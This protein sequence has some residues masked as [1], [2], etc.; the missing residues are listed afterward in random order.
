MLVVAPALAWAADSTS[1]T[2]ASTSFKV[3]SPVPSSG[4]AYAI[5]PGDTFQIQFDVNNDST[6]AVDLMSLA[7]RYQ[8]QV[9]T[10]DNEFSTIAAAFFESITVLDENGGVLGTAGAITGPNTTISINTTLGAGNNT[11]PSKDTRR[12]YLCIKSALTA[13]QATFYIEVKSNVGGGVTCDDG[14]GNFATVTHDL[15][16]DVCQIVRPK[17][18][19]AGAGRYPKVIAAG[20]G[21]YDLFEWIVRN[22]TAGTFTYRG[23]TYTCT[24]VRG[25]VPGAQNYY[26]TNPLGFT[27]DIERF[28]TV[29]D[30]TEKN[31]N[32]RGTVNSPQLRN[33][34]TAAPFYT[35]YQKLR[36]DAD[37]DDEPVDIG[38]NTSRTMQLAFVLNEYISDLP[39]P[40]GVVPGDCWYASLDSFAMTIKP[41]A[42]SFVK[43]QDVTTLTQRISTVIY[44]LMGPVG[45]RH[46]V[47]HPH[48]DATGSAYNDANDLEFTTYR[49]LFGLALIG[50]A[51]NTQG[52][53][54]ITLN[55]HHSPGLDFNSETSPLRRIDQTVLSGLQIRST[56]DPTYGM[57]DPMYPLDASQTLVTRTS[58]NTTRVQL[59][60]SGFM[61]L[62]TDSALHLNTTDQARVWIGVE[63]SQFAAFGD[64][65]TFELPPGGLEFLSGLRVY[66]T[67][68]QSRLSAADT[69]L[70]SYLKLD[71]QA[72][73]YPL[74]ETAA[75]THG[76]PVIFRDLTS[77]GQSVPPSSQAI[78]CF[79]FNVWDSGAAA[80]LFEASFFLLDNVAG[81]GGAIHEQDFADLRN[82]SQSGW[83]IYRDND[84]HP[85]NTNGVFDPNIDS[86]VPFT[87]FAAAQTR[88][89]PVG[90]PYSATL[91]NSYGAVNQ[92]LIVR[93]EMD[94]SNAATAVPDNDRDSNGGDDF[95][96]VF[97]TSPTITPGDRFRVIFGDLDNTVVN[98]YNYGI[99][100]QAQEALYWAAPDRVFSGG[101]FYRFDTACQDFG[102]DPLTWGLLTQ[103]DIQNNPN[104]TGAGSS[105]ILR[106][107]VIA[108]T[109]GIAVNATNLVVGPKTVF[110]GNELPLFGLNAV[111][112]TGGSYIV[113][114]YVDLIDSG[115]VLGDFDT[116]QDLSRF[117]SNLNTRGQ[118]LTVFED[119][120]TT[121]GVFDAGDSPVN[122]IWSYDS[123]FAGGTTRVKFTFSPAFDM[124]DTDF[125]RFAGNDIFI[126]AK[127]GD[128]L[129][130]RDDFAFRLPGNTT[131]NGMTFA[132]PGFISV[133]PPVTTGLL[134]AG[135]PSVYRDLPDSGVLSI[136][137]TRLAVM[138]IM[139]AD[140][141]HVATNGGI[142]LDQVRIQLEDPSAPGG[143]RTTDLLPLDV[144][145][146]GSGIW[147]WRDM[148]GSRTFSET[149]DTAL[150]IS[151]F[152]WQSANDLI[153]DVDNALAPVPDT[154]PFNLRSET[155]AVYFLVFR[156]AAAGL[157]HKLKVSVQAVNEPL[158]PWVKFTAPIDRTMNYTSNILTISPAG[159]TGSFSPLEFSPNADGVTDTIRI[160][161]T[162]IPGNLDSSWSLSAT[163]IASNVTSNLGVGKFDSVVFIGKT[164][165]AGHPVTY[166]WPSNF[167]SGGAY[168]LSFAYDRAGTTK[169]YEFG[170]TLLVD[171]SCTAPVL[172][173]ALPTVLTS[174]STVAVSI[175]SDTNRS[176]LDA[177]ALTAGESAA[178]YYIYRLDGTVATLLVSGTLANYVA[179]NVSVPIQGGTNNLV[180]NLRDT[181]GNW[182]DTK[183]LGAVTLSIGS[184]QT[185]VSDILTDP[186]KR[187]IGLGDSAAVF[188]INVTQDLA[189]EAI[190][191]ITLRIFD[192]VA[193]SFAYGNNVASVPTTGSYTETCG[194][195]VYKDNTAGGVK[196]S[197]D[198]ADII[199]PLN[200]AQ[201]NSIFSSGDTVRLIPQTPLPV[202][203]NDTSATYQGYDY[204]VVIV[205]GGGGY[206]RDSFTLQMPATTAFEF[207]TTS[208]TRSNLGS[209][210]TTA[211]I[212]TRIPRTF[213]DLS[214][215]V[216]SM[217]VGSNAAAILGIHVADTTR[218]VDGGAAL[219]TITLNF[220][221][222]AG[223]TFNPA[224]LAFSVY[225]D[226]GSTD[227]GSFNRSNDSEVTTTATILS[228]TSVLLTLSGANAGI[229]GSDAGNDSGADFW[230]AIR[231]TV[232]AV[233][234]ANKFTPWIP[235]GGVVTDG[236]SPGGLGIRAAS[237]ITI[238]VGGI[239][240]LISPNPFRPFADRYSNAYNYYETAGYALSFAD[241]RGFTVW[242]NRVTTG[243]TFMTITGYAKDTVVVF[244]RT[245]TTNWKMDEYRVTLRDTVTNLSSLD[246]T[247][248]YADT[249]ALTPTLG[250]APPASTTGTSLSVTIRVSELAENASQRARSRSER[251][252]FMLVFR[253]TAADG[254]DSTDTAYGALTASTVDVTKTISLGSGQNTVRVTLV[255]KVGNYD[256]TLTFSISSGA[257]IIGNIGF[258]GNSPLFRY[259]SA[260]PAFT[261]TFPTTVSGGTLEFFNI[262]GERMK[263]I[264]LP[265]GISSV[266]WN[267][268]NDAGQ[269]L[270]N[271]VYIIKFKVPL[272]NGT[273]IEESRTIFLLK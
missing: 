154:D 102:Q 33:W 202:P 257:A 36:N 79:G 171:L 211:P 122:G 267:A 231:P 54:K 149:A 14:G 134:T 169:T 243:E 266:D 192:S 160:Q 242:L 188:G 117:V 182:S 204:Y 93:L 118:G 186:T 180:A 216:D 130:F 145:D 210:V 258:E 174:G 53:R 163:H 236:D 43:N 214:A 220:D 87:G 173:S 21:P 11:I 170:D 110:R 217:P 91:L 139:A 127:I 98:T 51:N 6:V 109:G 32:R 101:A 251:D 89:V 114:L 164:A 235:A 99:S 68:P 272:S 237:A 150:Q 250:S 116:G 10:P 269:V 77:S 262:A 168:R 50:G 69:Y 56:S 162:I 155:Q 76:M 86:F 41:A 225:N 197:F 271:G 224:I 115:L 80:R 203:E 207:A 241:S 103:L 193:G 255:D 12:F 107:E 223:D 23:T 29:I 9:S 172:T 252:S 4:M 100:F 7:F 20:A 65:I 73:V 27:G 42:S 123:F 175:S 141:T 74:S 222:A 113:S 17:T 156:A 90:N 40:G 254:T 259:T 200:P 60:I 84:S 131:A 185:I 208:G 15:K 66:E 1:V 3:P 64:S 45:P 158:D 5:F 35:I 126:V 22:R 67:S 108:V 199:V 96:L 239:S 81:G 265:P 218:A 263:I 132:P 152:T 72:I 213:R 37:D 58:A 112:T 195:L 268:A 133:P 88:Y 8:D 44:E 136:D 240:T 179:T 105:D 125:G 39:Q 229:P 120:G 246:A 52:L 228:A 26:Q 198:A 256:S 206:Y 137:G 57:T 55:L 146:S 176:T 187:W 205:G 232:T 95:F 2:V 245:D 106:S 209:P 83:A 25:F 273:T 247:L 153:I 144:N 104:Y 264:N 196:G 138:G 234:V 140:S 151:S 183:T 147:I 34:S 24:N 167:T 31:F 219:R 135:M 248:L 78:A 46:R 121:E 249:Q 75:L 85:N 233:S 71:S 190:T 194:F 221:V 189:N 142:Y 124:P 230:I 178:N 119:V 28:I 30:G 61:P 161:F 16:S 253:T 38:A 260:N 19:T 159:V 94:T 63:P 97:R 111:D 201:R 148:D 181:Y 244:A 128:T 70:Q 227:I 261:F 47:V 18:A 215:A 82:D 166:A 157:D 92:P 191:A 165:V 270:R 184:N 13:P 129:L 59:V 212:V 143:Y 226:S 48:L 177:Y 62:S 238:P 49:P